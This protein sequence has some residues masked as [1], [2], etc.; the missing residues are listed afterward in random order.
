MAD[1]LEEDE[2]DGILDG[3]LEA[4]DAAAP[5][6]TSSHKSLP[7]SNA[8]LLSKPTISTPLNTP[9][10]T[11]SSDNETP[12]SEKRPSGRAVGAC[13]DD[14]TGRALEDAL[15]ELEEKSFDQGDAA[16][17][18][19]EADMKLVEEFMK[20]LS[21]LGTANMDSANATMSGETS[22]SRNNRQPG[23]ETLVNSIVGHLLSED[24]LKSPMIQMRA[25]YEQWLPNN[26]ESLSA[27]DL[28]RFSR[29]KELVEEIC[30]KYESNADSSE[31]ME[32]LSEMQKTGAPPDMVLKDLDDGGEAAQGL[33]GAELDKLADSC[34]MQ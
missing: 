12:S 30:E 31:I 21:S 6:H 4:F 20:S 3:A 9:T 14:D 24:V 11:S 26:K 8:S 25:A 19:M 34:G 17:D 22:S 1:D 5:Q 33:Q 13:G 28:D 2:L 7:Q 29:Q 10:K 27:Q 32:L 16:D 18:V 15:K 23:V